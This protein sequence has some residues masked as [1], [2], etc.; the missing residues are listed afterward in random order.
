M[1]IDHCKEMIEKYKIINPEQAK[2]YQE[3]INDANFIA[4]NGNNFTTLNQLNT[5]IVKKYNKE[6]ENEGI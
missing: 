6:K 1:T 2:A 3:V 4:C 5:I